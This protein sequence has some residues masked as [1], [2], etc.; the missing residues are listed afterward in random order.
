MQ[1]RSVRVLI[2]VAALIALAIG[3][4]N[5]PFVNDHLAWRVANLHASIEY[6]FHPPE[7][8]VF[9]PAEQTVNSPVVNTVL[10][11]SPI[12]LTP[13]PVAIATAEASPTPTN[14]PTPIPAGVSLQGVQHQYQKWNNCGPANLS[15][16]L[17]YWG[18]KGDQISIAAYTKPNPRDKNVMPEELADFVNTETDLKAIVR[19]AGDLELL[20]GFLAAGFPVIVEKGFEPESQLGWMGHYEVITAYSDGKQ[21]FTAQDSFL[22]P[23]L[24]VSYDGMQKQW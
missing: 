12:T 16:A 10:P 17:S 4:Y 24:T 1:N 9:H 19:V 6:F 7:Q 21:G 23:G 11:A 15:M 14:I 5:I 3:I 13:S 8:A 22:G 18:W 20:K 2:V